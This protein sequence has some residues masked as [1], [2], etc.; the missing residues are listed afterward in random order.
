MH[1][2]TQIRTKTL[3]TLLLFTPRRK[4]KK[5]LSENIVTETRYI[6]KC[7]WVECS[8]ILYSDGVVAP[9]RKRDNCYR[10]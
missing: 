2:P 5:I 10:D 7:A 9:Y 3:P 6:V 8:F 1:T 4:K